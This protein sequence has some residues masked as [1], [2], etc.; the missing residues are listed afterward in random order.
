[1]VW[2]YRNGFM[3]THMWIFPDIQLSGESKSE[4]NELSIF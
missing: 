3:F 2:V 1:M 4:E